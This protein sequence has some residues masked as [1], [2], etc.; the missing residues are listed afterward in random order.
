MPAHRGVR[1]E[2]GTRLRP[3]PMVKSADNELDS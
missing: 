3:C 2:W 1:D